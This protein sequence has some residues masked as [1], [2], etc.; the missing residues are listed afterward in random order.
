MKNAYII[1][2]FSHIMCDVACYNRCV[3][4]KNSFFYWVYSKLTGVNLVRG[5]HFKK[6]RRT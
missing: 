5:I 3:Q 6:K 2:G 1:M 4:N